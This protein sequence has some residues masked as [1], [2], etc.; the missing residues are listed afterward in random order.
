M[1]LNYKKTFNW[2]T[3]LA[4]CCCFSFFSM[5]WGLV[6]KL[7]YQTVWFWIWKLVFVLLKD[8]I[9]L[10]RNVVLWRVWWIVPLHVFATHFLLHVPWYCLLFFY[11]VFSV[12]P[13]VSNLEANSRKH[14]KN[15][16]FFFQ[17][18]ILLFPLSRC[19][20][21]QKHTHDNW[22]ILKE[23]EKKAKGTWRRK[24]V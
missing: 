9:Q 3:H 8:F 19:I 16:I 13:I 18:I 2:G 1:L 10:N 23:K 5:G 20:Y 17:N 14:K 22:K 24:V 6:G 21:T 4:W 12:R 15:R 11:S 7:C